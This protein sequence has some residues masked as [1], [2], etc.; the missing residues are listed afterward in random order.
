MHGVCEGVVLW[1]T[2]RVVC[3]CVCG[4]GAV[5]VLLTDPRGQQVPVSVIDN[6]DLTYRVEFTTQVSG[7]HTA[8]VTFAGLTVPRSPFTINVQ[9][10]TDA[11]KV[12]V[13]GLPHSQ[14]TR[15]DA[16]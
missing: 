5:S 15:V 14:S 13:R 11:S 4:V 1:V 7:V 12:Q 9:P 3:V 16:V 10:A 8:A 2:A 6:H